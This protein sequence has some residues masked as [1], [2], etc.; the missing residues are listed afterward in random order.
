MGHT[1]SLSP[2]V[3]MPSSSASHR[4]LVCT[5]CSMQIAFNHTFHHCWTHLTLQNN[6]HQQSLT[7][8]AWNMPQLIR[9][10]THRSRTLANKGYNY[11]E[12]SK[13]TNSF[14]RA[15]GSLVTK[16]NRNF[17]TSWRLR[18]QWGPLLPKGGGMIQLD[19]DGH[20]PIPPRP[21]S[22][23]HLLPCSFQYLLFLAF[24][25]VLNFQTSFDPL[26]EFFLGSTIVSQPQSG[27]VT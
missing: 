7:R 3:I 6:S 4:S 26:N 15:S 11:I 18:T 10:W 2:S 13:Q 19:I 8:I 24:F 5:W 25:R 9:S 12:L 14:T 1:P 23:F 16:F 17:L 22:Q 27:V 20:P 21:H